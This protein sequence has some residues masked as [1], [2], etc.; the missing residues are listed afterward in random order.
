MN[1]LAHLYLSGEREEVIIG[2]FIADHVKG[3]GIEVYNETIRQ[4]IR[5]HRAVDHYT[6]SH[7]IVRQSIARLRPVYRKYSGVIVDMYYDHFLAADWKEYSSV[8]LQAFTTSRYR[9]LLENMAVLPPR[10]QRIIPHMARYNWLKSYGSLAGLQQ[11]LS[12]MSGRTSFLSRMEHAIGD[13]RDGY[14]IYRNEF[15]LF[16][17]ELCRY[18]ELEFSDLVRNKS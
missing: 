1:Y 10:S 8:S 6:D 14:D 9:I 17:P 4:G 18:A 12:G 2:N 5:M 3:N 15:R 13:L 7:P 16:F 11:A